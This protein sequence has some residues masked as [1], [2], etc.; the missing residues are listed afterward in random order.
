MIRKATYDDV[1]ELMEVFRNARGI[2]R[3]SGNLHQWNDS[4]PSEEIVR[5][6]ISRGVCYV[7]CEGS[8]HPSGNIL[9]TMAFIPGPDPTYAQIHDGQWLDDSPYHVIHRIA[10]REPGHNAAGRLLK[11]A[12]TQTDNIRID[13]HKDNVIMHH[14]LRKYSFTHCGVIY[15]LSGDPRE[16]YQRHNSSFVTRND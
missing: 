11:W 1:P 5:E 9:A 4:Y 13:T 7:L 8:L 10:V 12:F 6:D 15:L 2:M 14:I 3:A 16:A